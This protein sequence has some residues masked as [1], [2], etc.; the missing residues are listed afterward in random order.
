MVT[1][2]SRAMVTISFIQG[3]VLFAVA[4]LAVR[5]AVCMRRHRVD[6]GHEARLL[7]M[8]VN[9]AVILRFTFFPFSRVDGQVQPL[10]FDLAEMLPLR[11]NLVPFKQLL[12]Y[13]TTRDLLINLIGNVAMFVPT[14]IVLPIVWPRLDR[15]WKVV[16]AGMLVSLC[17]E[18]LQLPFSSRGTD[19]DD[20]LL[21]TLG[22]TIGYVL[23]SLARGLRAK[24]DSSCKLN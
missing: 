14:G 9:L 7:L 8:Y 1:W 10:V 21:N 22:V 20:L 15:F 18:V 5:V 17:I 23:F 3:E 6:W 12:W 24:G 16:P 11:L 2:Y 4:W 19:V 13:E